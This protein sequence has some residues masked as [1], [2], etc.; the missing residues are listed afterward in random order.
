[1]CCGG[2]DIFPLKKVKL[3]F[4]LMNLKRARER[5]ESPVGEQLL[6]AAIT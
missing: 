1:M 4:C 6:L 3:L 2:Y 5:K